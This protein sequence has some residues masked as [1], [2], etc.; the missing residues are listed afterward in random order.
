[1]I[2]KKSRQ[3]II[4][5]I[6]LAS[7]LLVVK[8]IPLA[9]LFL[10]VSLFC[11][12]FFRDPTREIGSEIVAP[13][14]G[15]IMEISESEG[16]TQISIFMNLFDVHVNRMPIDGKIVG[17]ERIR[18]KHAMAFLPKAAENSRMKIDLETPIGKITL[19]QIAGVFA[20]RIVPYIMKGQMLMKGERIGLI[21]F[22]S[23]VDIFLPSQKTDV[24]V[25]LHQRVKAG[26][27]TLALI[28]S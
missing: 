6:L 5:P 4:A 14:D 17:I 24:T 13:A 16:K 12:F 19:V 11:L 15:K 27:S 18:G 2:A 9:I 3:F 7:I 26:F 22:G 20:W 23:R 8:M 1:M 28:K 10:T 25:H 21:R